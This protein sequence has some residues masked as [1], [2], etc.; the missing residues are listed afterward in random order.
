MDNYKVTR[1][2]LLDYATWCR[3]RA[4]NNTRIAVLG[5]RITRQS[6][7]AQWYVLCFAQATQGYSPDSLLSCAQIAE[8]LAYGNF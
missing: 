6:L 2:G 8:S 5:D 4:E 7:G 1:K 3:R